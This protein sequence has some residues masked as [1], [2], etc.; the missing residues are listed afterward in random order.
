MVVDP[1]LA[2][3]ETVPVR[4]QRVQIA[5]PQLDG[6]KRLNAGRVIFHSPTRDD[7]YRK[8][9]NL[10]LPHFAVRHLGKLP[11]EMPLILSR[12]RSTRPRVPS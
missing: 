11:E 4:G 8:A 5:E 7:V 2:I 6:R 10:R 9:V 3:H 1:V 12:F